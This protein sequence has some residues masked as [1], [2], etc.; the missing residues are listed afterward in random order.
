[1]AA[2]LF[3]LGGVG[4]V[5]RIVNLHKWAAARAAPTESGAN[6]I[7]RIMRSY[8]SAGPFPGR[9]YDPAYQILTRASGARYMPSPGWMSNAS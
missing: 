5:R 7:V 9:Q 4:R 6:D 2:L 8:C 1:M 3:L